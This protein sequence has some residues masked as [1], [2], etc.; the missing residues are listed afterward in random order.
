[1]KILTLITLSLIFLISSC[2]IHQHYTFKKDGSG[3][4][5]MTLDMR[6]ITTAFDE[7]NPEEENADLDL[8]EWGSMISEK[9]GVSN[10]KANEIEYGL[11]E[12]S[13]DFVEFQNIFGTEE[14]KDE[15][16]TPEISHKKRKFSF[17]LAGE[18]SDDSEEG[19]ENIDGVA[20]MLTNI[21]FTFEFED[22]KIRKVKSD[23]EIV[24]QGDHS[25]T[26]R[27]DPAKMAEGKD[28]FVDLKLR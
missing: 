21:L 24:E 16:P 11:Y 15:I 23:E 5:K 3:T 12:I 10:V 17:F 1:M 22:R 4:F 18:S 7:E 28:F 13:Y 2:S 8:D 6:E 27:Y 19:M 9:E 25:V 20:S 26:F 14:N